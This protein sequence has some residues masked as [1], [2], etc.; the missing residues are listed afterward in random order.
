MDAEVQVCTSGPNVLITSRKP[1][2]LP[3]FRQRLVAEFRPPS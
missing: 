3:A 2:D 1:D